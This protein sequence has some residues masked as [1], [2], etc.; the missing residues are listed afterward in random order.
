MVETQLCPLIDNYEPDSYYSEAVAVPASGEVF[1]RAFNTVADKDWVS[2]QAVAGQ[3]YT[4]TTV[5]IDHDVD[6]VLQ[7]Y[8]V[9]GVT[10]LQ[11]NDDY[12]ATTSAS[13]IVWTAPTTDKYYV[14]ITHFDH[15]YDPRYALTCG[16]HYGISIVQEIL[17]LTKFAD[18]DDP[19]LKPGDTIDYT[20]VVWNKLNTLQT[21]IVITDYVPMYTTYVTGSAQTN[22]GR[23]TG[24]DPLL[25]RVPILRAGGR[26]T[27]TF[28]VA[29]TQEG[30]GQV[31]R[32]Q[33]QAGSDQQAAQ[34]YT[35]IVV[36]EAYYYVYLP[37]VVRNSRAGS[38]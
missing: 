21:N 6:T 25:V 9:D 30:Q 22:L 37:L 5:D 11:R 32:N 23:L 1:T 10:L 20:I 29:V 33:A 2:F 26:I 12:T 7:L 36:T 24:P 4:I 27:V 14:R 19:E 38:R 18:V 8:D 15:T 17:G 31:I 3:V 13:R 16:G 28:Q 35:P 34:A